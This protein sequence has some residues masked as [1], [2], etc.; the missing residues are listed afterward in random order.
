MGVTYSNYLK[1]DELLSLQKERARPAA[2]D[3]LLFITVHQAHELWF[4]QLLHESEKLRKDL[5]E[6][7]AWQAIKSMRRTLCILKLLVQHSDVLE[8][9]SPRN[10][11][12][13]RLFLSQ[14]SGL[15]SYQFRELEIVCGWRHSEA[16][17]EIFEENSTARK[18]ISKRLKEST[19]WEAFYRFLSHYREKCP[20]L[21]QNDQRPGLYHL[22][23][24]EL[25]AYICKLVQKQPAVDILIELFI[26]FDEGF[27]EWRYRHVKI[28]ERTIGDKKQGTGGTNG[29]EYLKRSLHRQFFP[30]LWA[31]RTYF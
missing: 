13:F 1:L 14:A 23:S 20:P 4:K 31:I 10:F 17:Y 12:K 7:H 6:G 19:L 29:L 3:E 30:D 11:S 22:P 26:D 5:E 25:Q 16:T 2:E 8:T 18:N 9:M 24:E 27:Q 21:Q 28:V 15:Q